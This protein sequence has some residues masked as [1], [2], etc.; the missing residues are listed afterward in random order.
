MSLKISYRN[1]NIVFAN[2]TDLLQEHVRFDQTCR[3]L[4]D[5]LDNISRRYQDGLFSTDTVLFIR[6]APSN[7]LTI[8]VGITKNNNPYLFVYDALEKKVS[9]D[10]PYEIFVQIGKAP[11]V[12][13]LEDAIKM[14]NAYKYKVFETPEIKA[15]INNLVKQ[16]DLAVKQKGERCEETKTKKGTKN[17]GE[18]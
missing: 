1:V 8:Y 3:V 14:K 10:I 9:K 6:V 13:M 18:H 17:E 11:Y 16:Y 4:D 15:Q 5:Y 7:A 2:H 12:Y